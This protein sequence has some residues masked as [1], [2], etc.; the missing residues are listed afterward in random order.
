[1]GISIDIS[2][3]DGFILPEHSSLVFVLL[4]MRCLSK[5]S[6][7]NAN[8]LDTL[9]EGCHGVL[10][11]GTWGRGV[12]RRTTSYIRFRFQRVNGTICSRL[13]ITFI[14]SWEEALESSSFE[15]VGIPQSSYRLIL[16]PEYPKLVDR[17]RLK[18][19]LII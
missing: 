16:T 5:I 3:N 13:R 19:H 8:G 11:E 12:K 7:G 9:N 6:P 18:P 10:K 14:R 4:V 2:K 17:R 1:M 15:T